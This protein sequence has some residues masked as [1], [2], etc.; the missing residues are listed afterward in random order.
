LLFKRIREIWDQVVAINQAR[1]WV[2][3]NSG[4]NFFKLFFG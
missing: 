3:K 2:I 4:I 1:C